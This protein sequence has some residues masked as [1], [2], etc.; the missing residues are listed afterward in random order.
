MNIPLNPAVF[1]KPLAILPLDTLSLKQRDAQT[2]ALKKY[3]ILVVE[4][5]AINQTI[6]RYA[7][8]EPDFEMSLAQTGEE[9]LQL[10]EA[11]EYAL[12]LMDIGLPGQLQGTD[13]A[14][15]IRDMERSKAQHI[16]IIACTANPPSTKTA[17]L[18]AGIDDFISKPY[19]LAELK[20]RVK[21]WLAKPKI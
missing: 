14:R 13:V 5:D 3:K 18:A 17:Y 11:E 1:A 7:L 16:P 21:S 19:D 10:Y 15:L 6:A 9:A 4:D 2:M 12:I 20:Q 8:D